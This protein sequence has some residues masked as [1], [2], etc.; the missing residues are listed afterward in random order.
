MISP[1]STRKSTSISSSK[2]MFIAL[3]PCDAR[4]DGT[5]E[6]GQ[7]PSLESSASTSS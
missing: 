3:S 1:A 6:D 2:S 7:N 4:L 5:T